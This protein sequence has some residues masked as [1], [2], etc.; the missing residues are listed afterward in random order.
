MAPPSPLP[1]PAPTH[2]SSYYTPLDVCSLVLPFPPSSCLFVKFNRLW[3][4]QLARSP[5]SLSFLAPFSSHLCQYEQAELC[6]KKRGH[7]RR[8]AGGGKP[9]P[10]PNDH[11]FPSALR[12]PFLSPFAFPMLTRIA[13]RALR[14]FFMQQR[15]RP[16]RTRL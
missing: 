16:R 12:G 8:G 15:F 14:S 10:P 5:L 1:L 6:Q 2:V 3:P 13:S 7:K 4:Y 11:D 9:A